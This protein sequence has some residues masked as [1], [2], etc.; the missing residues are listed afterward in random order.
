MSRDLCTSK[1]SY[2]APRYSL[3]PF[4][5][6]YSWLHVQFYIPLL[7]LWFT[8][9]GLTA[10]LTTTTL[11]STLISS[12][13]SSSLLGNRLLPFIL[14]SSLK[15]CRGKASC[16]NV[17]P[18]AHREVTIITYYSWTSVT[19][20]SSFD[21]HYLLHHTVL[22]IHT[23]TCTYSFCG[24]IL[25][26]FWRGNKSFW[27]NSSLSLSL[28]SALILCICI[29]PFLTRDDI[30]ILD[31]S[32]LATPLPVVGVYTC[33]YMCSSHRQEVYIYSVFNWFN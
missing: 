5:H 11:C 31:D 9:R 18:Q 2:L 25:W 28:G 27:D 23:I 12:S 33:M 32:S 26:T 1:N 10:R 30:I 21:D 15:K 20:K 29:S 7:L 14:I 3:L 19:F 8:A 16:Y 17:M 22:Y 24:F 13:H 6:M 4:L